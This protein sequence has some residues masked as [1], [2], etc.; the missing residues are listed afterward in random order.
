MRRKLSLT[1]RLTLF[2]ISSS[3]LVLLVFS[4]VITIAVQHHFS[5]QDQ[6]NLQ[7]KLQLVSN[8]LS[9]VTAHN[10]KDPKLAEYLRSALVG[11]EDLQVLILTP[12]KFVIYRSAKLSLP[13]DL[14]D[15]KIKM[16]IGKP[17]Q[18]TV[19]SQHFLGLIAALEHG[20]HA[21]IVILAYNQNNHRQFKLSFTKTLVFF[22]LIAALISGLLAWF[23]T[24]RGLLPLYLIKD[25]ALKVTANQLD[26][27]M[28]D[29]DVPIEISGLAVALNQM[30]DRLEDAFTRLTQFSNEIAHELRTPVSNLMT[31][32]QVVLSKPRDLA[33]YR[34]VLE[35]N[36]EEYQRM[37]S[38]LSDML[39]LA[40]TEQTTN[41]LKGA[42]INLPDEAANL[43]EFYDALAEERKIS[44]KLSANCS[45]KVEIIGDV[46]MI[47]RAMSNLL[48]NAI[49]HTPA[50]GTIEIVINK[51]L[52]YTSLSVINSGLEIPPSV[53]PH[54]F[55]RFYTTANADRNSA[56]EVGTGLGLAITEA[57]I[58]AHQGEI[59]VTSKAGFTCFQ[60]IFR[61][62]SASI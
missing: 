53:L 38:M 57:I 34:G 20:D 45:D 37:T 51:T 6:Q 54:L 21:I 35:S 43:F 22:T 11:H 9:K 15:T 17:M 18:W 39:F 41:V 36:V 4:W 48:S 24:R 14:V 33:T 29:E 13:L 42:V 8:I 16:G 60:L 7:G 31:Q 62:R 49:N 19:G 12:Q 40:K 47:R 44:L 25:Q 3:C 5:L 10:S 56:L 32:T 23:V 26:Q 52:Q 55:E 30:L 59:V 58:K 61:E 1:A 50:Q 28:P 2:Y 46:S 27:R